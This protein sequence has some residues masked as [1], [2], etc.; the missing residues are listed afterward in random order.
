[1]LSVAAAG[2]QVT[3]GA[4]S[5]TQAIP[6]DSG[7]NRARWVRLLALGNCYVRPCLAGGVATTAD[8]LL[9]PNESV[10]LD[11]RAFTHI[12]HIQNAAAEKFNITPLEAAPAD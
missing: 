2:T 8:M 12:A 1:M 5:G 3:T 7:G 9:S 11:V 10:I 4:A 6:N